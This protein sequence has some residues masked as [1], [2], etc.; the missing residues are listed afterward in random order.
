VAA[1]H[2][3]FSEDARRRVATGL[4]ILADA[5][6][7]TL[8]PRGRN[9]LV[10]R[11]WG[12]PLITKDGV[13]V[14]KEIDISDKF[15]NMGVQV[16][17]E[18]AEK[19]ADI[20]GD[21]TTTATVL[22][23]V[24][25][26][27]GMR[28]VA[29]GHSPIEIKRGIDAAVE[30]IVEALKALS[31]PVQGKK[32]IAQI[33]TISANGES[34]IGEMLAEAMEKVGREGVITV[35]ENQSIKTE[36][37]VVEG[38]QFDRGY[39]SP[40]FVT[41]ND[42]LVV[43]LEN[44]FVLIC[45][46]KVSSMK[47]LLPVL[48][49][50][51]QQGKPLLV[52]AEDVEGEALATLVI[53]KL[54]GS[55]ACCAVKAPGFGDRR[56]AMLNDIAILTGGKAIMTDLGVKLEEVPLTDLGRC[57]RVSIDVDN[58]TIVDGAGDKEAIKARCRE[59]EKE[60]T[61]TNS[62]WDKDKLRER[63]AKVAGGVAIIKVGAASD[64][65]S[66]EKRDRVDDALHATRAAVQEGIVPGGGVALLRCQKAL[67]K[68]KFDDERQYGVNLVR[69]A[70]EEPLRQIA[71][72]A[73]NEP[74]VVVERVREGK[75]GFGYN[76]ETDEFEDLLAAGVIDPAKVV[77]VALQNAA[78][79]AGL[80][81]TTECLIGNLAKPKGSPAP[82]GPPPQMDDHHEDDDHDH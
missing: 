79:V 51:A 81:L 23:Q 42:K 60:I 3:V 61:E 33:G 72:N 26:N 16:V 68:L 9:V 54:R 11:P 71:D 62:D 65:E 70:V 8:G 44:P 12:V 32:E 14:A 50:V 39:L 55:L 10:E 4:N 77:R 63:L 34:E 15:A 18:V 17:K 48:E 78:S 64:A 29:A 46:K 5:V 37:K 43:E 45:E 7:V 75:D 69:R 22:T 36:L 41:N 31:K 47:E 40:Y 76:A 74:S 2:I 67:A 59:I 82:E 19:T 38:M 80:M 1:K 21:G 58:C 73:G 52:I 20:A 57:K 25:Y 24:I 30:S 53:N 13:T 27:E 28:L 56:K 66:R 35:E 49:Q 6:K